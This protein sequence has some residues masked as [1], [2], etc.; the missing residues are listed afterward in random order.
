MLNAWKVF[1]KKYT[2]VTPREILAQPVWHNHHITSDFIESWQRNLIH[3][4][5][6]M[7]LHI[8]DANLITLQEQTLLT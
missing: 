7:H 3:D 8:S 5:T 4:L 6:D 2:P 1:N